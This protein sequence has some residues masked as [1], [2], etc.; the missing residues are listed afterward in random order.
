MDEYGIN[1]G[2]G[3][4]KNNRFKVSKVEKIRMRRGPKLRC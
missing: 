1:L 4:R 2:E 3:S